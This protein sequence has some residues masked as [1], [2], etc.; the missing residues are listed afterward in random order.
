MLSNKAK[1]LNGFTIV[2]LTVALLVSAIVL[3][4]GYELFKSLRSV[5]DAQDQSLAESWEMIN[6]L[7]RIREDLIQA[8]PRAYGQETM[9]S[10]HSPA[11]EFEEFKLLQFYSLCITDRPNKV[12][13]IR[14]I[15]K[16][17]YELVKE[18]GSIHLY[19]T[20]TPMVA[21]DNRANGEYRKPIF[22]KIEEIKIFFHNG[23]QLKP[24]FSSKQYLP[25]YVRLELTAWGQTWP[26]VVK[27]PCGVMNMEQ[28]L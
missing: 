17:E 19:R 14:Q 2:E 16:I 28:A 12:S 3:V 9:F 7:D 11:A 22:G 27:L 8:V 25:V 21:K 13:G 20:A 10:G 24:S 6:V 26:L 18:K 15:H 23:H 5:G 1:I 4:T